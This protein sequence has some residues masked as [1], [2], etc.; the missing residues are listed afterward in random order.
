MIG[1]FDVSLDGKRLTSV[2]PYITV[3]DIEYTTAQLEDSTMD[4]AAQNGVIRT[5]RRFLP[6][7]VTVTYDL[8]I[9][10][11][12]GRQKT[13]EAISGWAIN[14]GVLRTSDRYGK[15][16]NVQCAAS[17]VMGSALR[18]TNQ[19]SLEFIAYENP[20]WQSEKETTATI[21]SSG[22]IK[23]DGNVE[24]ARAS[25]TIT[26]GAK[27]TTL[28]VTCDQTSLVFTGLNTSSKIYIDYDS[29]GFLTLKA[30]STDIMDKRSGSDDL[31]LPCG[32]TSSISVSANTSV[33]CQIRARGQW[34]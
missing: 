4:K 22:T 2:S 10:N 16:L 5:K 18:W 28:V 21:T 31:R 8:S 9:Y 26:P 33:S 19:L 11:P 3:V 7:R 25:A 24:Y 6:S 13:F 23:L 27:L 20:F 14:G 12:E 15:F 17:P 32:K 30:G 1:R 34:L 29:N